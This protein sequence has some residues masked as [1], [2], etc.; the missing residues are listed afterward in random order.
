MKVA[1]VGGGIAGLTAAY[2][3]TQGGHNVSLFEA[4]PELGG[5]VRT[6]DVRGEPLEAFYHHIFS[7]DTTIV[8]L[9]EEL[10]LGERLVW[11][12]SKV[13]FYYKGRL[14]PFVTPLDLL[15][16][17]PLPLIDRVRLGLAGLYLRRQDDW[18]RYEE[19]TAWEWLRR[20]VGQ[21]GLDV[22]WG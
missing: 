12:D 4:G 13:G 9:A 2:R 15:R 6:F 14:W 8:R 18:H 16:F 19:V 20:Y 21:K 10:G 3:L 1:I 11:K 17:E 22:V 7:T 5:L